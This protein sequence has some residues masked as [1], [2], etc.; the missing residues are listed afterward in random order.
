[1]LSLQL[2]LC[3][4]R[5]APME[6]KVVAHGGFFHSCHNSGLAPSQAQLLVSSCS[7]VFFFNW[8]GGPLLLLVVVLI[9]C[10]QFA[11]RGVAVQTLAILPIAT[12]TS[13]KDVNGL[14][15][16]ETPKL[17]K[18]IGNWSPNN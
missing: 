6:S 2:F 15:A 11:H 1:M 18:K 17:A 7:S 14:L 13:E 9:V 12:G 10:S 5:F 16:D 3:Q 4:E 8:Q